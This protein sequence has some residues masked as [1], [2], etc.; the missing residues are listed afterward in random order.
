M[1]RQF[2]TFALF[3]LTLTGCIGESIEIAPEEVPIRTS[4]SKVENPS[5]ALDEPTESGSRLRTFN[6]LTL[7]IPDG[8]EEIELSDFQRGVIEAKYRMP[9]HGSDLT[10]TVS[11]A[12]GGID[13]NFDRWRGQVTGGEEDTDELDAVGRK[14]RL[15]ELTGRFSGG[16][17]RDPQNDWQLTG[18]GIPS[19]PQDMYLKL[20]GPIE[21]AR[22]AADD[23]RAL[24][25]S[26]RA[27][28]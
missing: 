12:S 19:E 24:A 23:V 4:S 27:A 15:I 26:V 22:E 5:K 2:F 9:K 17:G 11:F 1:A 3:S 14:V 6:N 20:T 18:M 28:R 8:W 13:A 21:Q 16:F 25:R 7:R 10:L